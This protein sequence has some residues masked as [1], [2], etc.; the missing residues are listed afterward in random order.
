AIVPHDATVDRRFVQRA[1]A[2]GLLV[3]P[4][5]VNDEERMA[6]L[7]DLGVDGII[8]D[9]PDVARVVVDAPADQPVGEGG[10]GAS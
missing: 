9:L 10:N 6:E 3:Y 1:H 4:W 7:V 8:T 5:T 2:A